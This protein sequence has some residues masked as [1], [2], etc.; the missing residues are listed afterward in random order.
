[1]LFKAL[2]V[3][4]SSVS[5]YGYLPNSQSQFLYSFVQLCATLYGLLNKNNDVLVLQRQKR[6]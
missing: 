1:M 2:S 5:L 4:L 6:G 3:G